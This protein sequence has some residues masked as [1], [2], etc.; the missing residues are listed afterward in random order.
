M[1]ILTRQAELRLLPEGVL[2][3]VP[4]KAYWQPPPKKK[5]SKANQRGKT[6]AEIAEYAANI[7][8]QKLQKERQEEAQKYIPTQLSGS[9]DSSHFLIQNKEP[10]NKVDKDIKE[11]KN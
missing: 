3:K 6:S 10:A 4:P 2:F 1:T 11:V 8:V 7:T 9:V 5:Y